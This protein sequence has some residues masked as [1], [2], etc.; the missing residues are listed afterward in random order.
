MRLPTEMATFSKRLEFVESADKRMRARTDQLDARIVDTNEMLEQRGEQ[1]TALFESTNF[2][3]AQTTRTTPGIMCDQFDEEASDTLK[4]FANDILPDSI[5]ENTWLMLVYPM[6]EEFRDATT[7]RTFMKSRQ[8]HPQTGQL[9]WCWVLISE[10][11]T[12]EQGSIVRYVEKFTLW[13]TQ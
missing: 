10:E 5:P 7:K 12:R 9:F 2:V 6:H 4:R 8:V 11:D 13:P 1:I 3:F